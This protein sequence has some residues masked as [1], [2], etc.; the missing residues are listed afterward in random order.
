MSSPVPMQRALPAFT[1]RLF[2]LVIIGGGISGACIAHDA[3]LRGLDVALVER[4][5][6][7]GATSSASSKILHGGVRYLQQLRVDKV[8]ESVRERAALRRIAPHLS[9][10]VPFLVVTHESP[11]R[12]R[13][14]LQAGLSAYRLLRAMGEP[15]DLAPGGREPAGRFYDREALASVAPG[16]V[17]REDV[18]GAHEIHECHVH[19]TERMTLAFLKTAVSHG[20]QVANYVSVD[21]RLDQPPGG[22]RATDRLTGDQL[23]IRARVVVNAAGPWVT[24]LNQRLGVETLPRPVTGWSQ[25][26]HLVTRQV[27]ADVAVALS[28]GRPSEAVVDRGGR[29]VFVI[30]WRGHSLIGTSNTPLAAGPDTVGPTE[31]DI[32]Q[33]LTDVGAALPGRA[34]SRGDVCHAFAGVYPLTAAELQQDTYQ[35][36]GDFQVVD[37]T[38][39]EPSGVVTALGAKYTT[40]RRLAEL[41]TS[42]VVEKLGGSAVCQTATTP[43]VGSDVGDVD[44]FLRDATRR[45]S[46]ELEAPRVEHLVRAYG[47]EVDD[48]LALSRQEPALSEA[49]ASSRESIGAEVAFAVECEMAAHL[50]D[51]VFRRT[52]L[53]TL[54]YP[55]EP[56][57]ERCASIM[58]ARLGWTAE[59]T[60]AELDETRRQFPLYEAAS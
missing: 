36:T 24:P 18:T 1:D 23:E 26:A 43:L 13:R 50:S 3:A 9:H 31:A 51:V 25:G 49:L 53:G 10:W 42:L 48:V 56:A 52:G 45:L 20:A 34:P 44:T 47:S 29:H 4:D 57:L 40:A 12:G 35:G 60:Q 11:L 6:F 46:G 2:D 8:V 32:E 38:P 54:G 55:G 17:S 5:D 33:L 14:F 16:L 37:H 41:V 39:G 27:F 30:P 58:R 19:S 59:E 21:D 7:G 15:A 28:T 22:V